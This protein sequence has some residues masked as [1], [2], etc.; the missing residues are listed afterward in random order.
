LDFGAFKRNFSLLAL[1]KTQHN[2]ERRKENIVYTIIIVN[3]STI[4]L[5]GGNKTGFVTFSKM[6]T[7]FVTDTDQYR[8]DDK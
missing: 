2:H 3:V 5:E 4:N 7:K 1:G 6:K 8:K